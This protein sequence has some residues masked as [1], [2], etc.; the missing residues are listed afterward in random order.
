M[1][2]CRDTLDKHFLINAKSNTMDANMATEKTYD[3][4]A[5]ANLD[6]GEIAVKFFDLM[7]DAEVN[8]EELIV[9][10]NGEPVARFAPDRA[11]PGLERN[12]F[13]FGAMRHEFEVVGDIDG[14]MPASWFAATE[15]GCTD[16]EQC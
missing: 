12:R 2:N 10:K 9:L 15:C 3:M 11:K 6:Y 8:G 5:A 7:H 1:A 16:G 14:P 13:E 4:S